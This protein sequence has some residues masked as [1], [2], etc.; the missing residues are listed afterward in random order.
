MKKLPEEICVIGYPS[1]CGGADTELLHQ[2]KCWSIMGIKTHIIPTKDNINERISLDDCN[3]VVHDYMDFKSCEGLHTLSFCNP[4]FLVYAKEIKKYARSTSWA[5]CMTFNFKTELEAHEK[6][7]IDYFLYQTK[8]QY[9]S[10]APW[11]VKTN[12]NYIPYQFKP[13][14]DTFQFPYIDPDDR[15]YNIVKF[16]R[17]SRSDISKF[18][19]HQFYIY[20][21]IQGPK[22]GIVLGWDDSMKDKFVPRNEVDDCNC[23][24]Y[25]ENEISQ[26][27]FYKRCNILCMST[28]T[29]E[30]L[31]RVAFECMASGCL[32]VVDDR[33]GWKSIIENRETGFLCKYPED[34]IFV[35][36][37]LCKDIQNLKRVVRNS[38]SWLLKNFSQQASIKSWEVF[39]K[40]I[41]ARTI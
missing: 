3:V 38:Y 18:S 41:N 28:N 22:S 10:L 25:K 32:L 40:T 15:N 1:N 27:E 29:Y 26:Q 4:A 16:G 11:L 23:V 12:S 5:N 7:Y 35:M 2:I 6:G 33:G 34:F 13:Y 36:N 9:N 17:I 30:N 19:K 20:K 31:P 8:H 14:F 39:F 24:F 37:D 21:R